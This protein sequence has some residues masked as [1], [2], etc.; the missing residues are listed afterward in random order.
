MSDYID[1]LLQET[2]TEAHELIAQIEDLAAHVT[3]PVHQ[4]MARQALRMRAVL[5]AGEELTEQEL[6]RLRAS[7]EALAQAAFGMPEFD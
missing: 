5:E 3:H 7:Y 1:D 6:S 4:V 2:E